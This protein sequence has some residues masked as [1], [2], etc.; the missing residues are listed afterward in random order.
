[1]TLQAGVINVD[2]MGLLMGERQR[3]V[4]AVVTTTTGAGA[5]QADF[6][7]VPLARNAA[8]VWSINAAALANLNA[9]CTAVAATP[10]WLG[11]PHLIIHATS[12]SQ[13]KLTSM[14]SIVESYV[15]A[16][17]VT[18]AIGRDPTKTR[19][20]FRVP[21]TAHATAANVRI[22]IADTQAMVRNWQSLYCVAAHEFG[23]CIGLPDEYL[24]YGGF[25]NLAIQQSQPRWN[26]LC[27]ALQA[28]VAPRDWHGQFNESMMSIGD[29]LYPAHAVTLWRALDD[30]TQLAPNLMAP[31]SW[32]V[33]NP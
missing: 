29:R 4:N 25:A 13:D 3:V 18:G 15:R 2:R 6:F 27:S 10:A 9:F 30:M 23:H 33:T 28:D 16:R 21:F 14:I 8:G 32:A 12:G 31:H 5:Q 7:D 24:D 17:G 11:Q 20:N 22:E 19:R 1:M 26:Q